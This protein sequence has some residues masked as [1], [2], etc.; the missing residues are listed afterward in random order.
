ML[1]SFGWGLFLACSQGPNSIESGAG[2]SLTS[3]GAAPDSSGAQPGSGGDDSG[4]TGGRPGG[5]GNAGGSAGGD[6]GAG[7]TAGAGGADAELGT[8]L[9]LSFPAGAVPRVTGQLLAATPSGSVVTV[10]ASSWGD[11]YPE[12]D[13]PVLIELSPSGAVLNARL[14]KGFAQPELLT[15]DAQGAVYLAGPLGS[16]I[17]LD[18]L[19]VPGQEYGGYLLK[20]SSSF[21]A[22]RGAA[23]STDGGTIFNTM[24][25]DEAGRIYLSLSV[26]P[27]EFD[28]MV[29]VLKAFSTETLDEEWSLPCEHS[30]SPVYAYSLDVTSEHELVAAGLFSG[31]LEM[32]SFDLVK[33]L[34]AQS[35]DF[36]YNG[37]LAWLDTET[38]TAESALSF[39]GL[40]T[41]AA[42]SFLVA[43]GGY[44]LL[45]SHNGESELFGSSIGEVPTQSLL[46]ALDADL[47]MKWQSPVGDAELFPSVMALGSS[48]QSYLV[49]RYGAFLLEDSDKGGVIMRV[50]ADGT[51]RPSLYIPSRNNNG[52]RQIVVDTLGGVWVSGFSEIPFDFE[53]ERFTPPGSFGQY[54]IRRNAF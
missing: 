30:A 2:G 27:P 21:Q 52:A 7:G 38:G 49:G 24:I 50:D 4:M 25:G 1:A 32:G 9:L 6:D 54:V 29:L 15:V 40:V 19:T 16:D 3:S 39:G 35:D 8:D 10:A 33:P 36:I 42:H 34:A 46:T 45:S 51:V 12:S 48:G 5:G 17:A 43:D 53:G 23:F 47:N 31:E 26:Y 20:L 13:E 22:E 18:E 14:L 41:D 44:R 37:W 11:L 28:R